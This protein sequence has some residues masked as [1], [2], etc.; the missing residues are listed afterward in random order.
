[1]ASSAEWPLAAL[2]QACAQARVPAPEATGA[3]VGRAISQGWAGVLETVAPLVP[4]EAWTGLLLQPLHGLPS[5]P[6]VLHRAMASP[7]ARAVLRAAL[8]EGQANLATRDGRNGFFLAVMDVHEAGDWVRRGMDPVHRD[9]QGRFAEEAFYLPSEALAVAESLAP[10]RDPATRRL[11]AWRRAARALV[12]GEGLLT[13]ADWTILSGTPPSDPTG[14][15]TALAALLDGDLRPGF[16]ARGLQVFLSRLEKEGALDAWAVAQ[17]DAARVAGLIWT[18]IQFRAT[19][20]VAGPT[21][22][23]LAGGMIKRLALPDDALVLG[24]LGTPLFGNHG[25]GVL[26]PYPEQVVERFLRSRTL[27]DPEAWKARLPGVEMTLKALMGGE[28]PALAS[29]LGSIATQAL[30]LLPEDDRHDPRLTGVV[31]TARLAMAV[32]SPL[33]LGPGGSFGAGRAELEAAGERALDSP[34]GG[35]WFRAQPDWLRN[36]FDRGAPALTARL[37]QAGLDS[38]LPAAGARPARPR[39]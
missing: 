33:A 5:N 11:A 34:E 2:L 38:E 18:A 20:G 12:Q 16:D 25:K 4:A 27:T 8:P 3:L 15:D 9:T 30:A 32:L 19:T 31:C 39:M 22:A 10:F 23:G 21:L 17:G 7:P 1:M 37:R 35:A 6:E 24:M 13:E 26:P 29:L 36:V 14:A 28:T